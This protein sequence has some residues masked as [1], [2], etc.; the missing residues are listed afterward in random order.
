MNCD[1]SASLMA[2]ERQKVINNVDL[3]LA[4]CEFKLGHRDFFNDLESVIRLKFALNL[5][6]LN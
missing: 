6:Y 3:S 4:F 2:L 1:L 5:I